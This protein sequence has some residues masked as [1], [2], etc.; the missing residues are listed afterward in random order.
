MSQ[1]NNKSANLN[2]LNL[3]PMNSMATSAYRNTFPQGYDKN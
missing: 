1:N 3:S 2:S